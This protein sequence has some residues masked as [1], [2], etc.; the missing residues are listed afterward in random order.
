MK[1]VYLIS[2]KSKVPMLKG[3]KFQEIIRS[4]VKGVDGTKDIEK[5]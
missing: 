1:D 2:I 5:F 3:I 4:T